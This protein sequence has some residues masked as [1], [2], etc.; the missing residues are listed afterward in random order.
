MEKSGE[1]VSKLHSI[2]EDERQDLEG[3]AETPEGCAL[4]QRD[5]DSLDKMS[6]EEP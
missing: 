6:Q 3:V 4:L 1:E 5:L 2:R